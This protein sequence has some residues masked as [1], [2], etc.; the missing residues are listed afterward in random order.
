VYTQPDDLTEETLLA[1]LLAGWG[2]AGATLRYL[3]VGFGSHHWLAAGSDDTKLFVTV[4][5]LDAKLSSETD[6]TDAAFGRL[7][8]AFA[9]ALSLHR[10]CG[11]QFVLAPVPARDGQ[12]L[13]R[14]QDRY[15]MVVHPY[16]P[17]EPAGQTSAY[18]DRA[19]VPDIVDLLVRL[20]RARPPSQPRP[21]DFAVP[22]RAELTAAMRETGHAW[23][24]GPYAERARSLLALHADDLAE[25]MAAFD[26]LA[27]RVAA[28]PDRMV[29]THG[30]PGAHNV[31]RTPAGLV[32]VDW[33]SAL[34][35]APERDL[36]DLSE[37]DPSILRAYS[38]ASGGR[39]DEDALAFYR[40]FYDLF[41]IAG[42]VQ[43]FRDDHGETADAAESWRNLQ[44]F[45]QPAARW[46]DVFAAKTR[47]VIPAMP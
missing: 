19:D 47:R 38:E 4:D 40:M 14:L 36:W 44:H 15:S 30:E 7:E 28:R 42:Y 2:F 24:S 11:L 13:T 46:P 43:L 31:L 41:E 9:T 18:S 12:V 1:G 45:L 39:V 34:L 16:L 32:L 22:L 10:D 6:S 20:H 3:P 27:A 25:L 8:R 33:D 23:H 5:D 17:G 35:A 26:G 29:V 21:D 37:H